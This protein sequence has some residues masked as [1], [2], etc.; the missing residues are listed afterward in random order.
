M[1]FTTFKVAKSHCAAGYGECDSKKLGAAVNTIREHF[2][3][4]Y[5]K[6]ELFMDAVE[7]FRVHRFAQD[8]VGCDEF[9]RGITLPRHFQNVEAMWVNN[10]P[11]RLRSEWR[12]F[13]IGIVGECEC[14][15]QKLDVPGLFPTAIDIRPHHATRLRIRALDVAD[16]GKRFVVRGIAGGGHPVKEEF[17]LT[18]DVQ[19][20]KAE[21]ASI[22]REAGVIKD[23]TEGRVVLMDSD[24]RLLSI[25]EPEEEIPGYRRIKITGIHDA[26][27]VVNIRASRKFFPLYGDDDAVETDSKVAFDSMA[28]Y[29]RLYEQADKTSESLKAEKDHY[30]TA[31]GILTGAK[32][33]ERGK[34]TEAALRIE[35]PHFGGG[36]RLNRFGPMRRVF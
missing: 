2:F 27:D 29:L 25:Y 22:D 19:E 5:E 35:S 17:D 34:S 4:W 18:T 6:L 7:C 13:Q 1:G 15:L 8:C 11:V 3:S 10:Y 24:N 21:F 20:T 32:S 12:E 36:Q 16:V 30:A 14:G 26:C 31:F 23:L 28:R 33:R 9:Y